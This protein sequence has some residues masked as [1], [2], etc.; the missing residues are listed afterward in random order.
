MS[1]N[2]RRAFLENAIFFTGSIAL[3]GCGSDTPKKLKT[4]TLAKDTPIPSPI[5]SPLPDGLSEDHFQLHNPQPLA[6][7]SKREMIGMSPITSTKRLFVRNNLPRPSDDIITNA[8]QWTLQVSGVLNPIVLSLPQLK[9]LGIETVTAVL[10]CSGNGRAFFTHEPSGSPWATGAAGCVQWTGV[11]VDD[12]LKACG[13]TL[14]SMN[15]LTATGGEPLP[16]D[17]PRNKA[18]VERSIPLKK[19]LKDCILAWELNGEPIPIS[20]GGPLRLIVPGYFGCNQIK[21]V[22]H[23][24]ATVEQS[25]AKI[26]QSGYRL[27]PIGEKGNHN[28]PSMWRMPVKSWVVDALKNPTNNTYIIHG[29]AFS[30]E[31]GI[32]EVE[33]S[34]D[35]VVWKKA[36]LYGPDLGPNAWRCFRINSDPNAPLL[37]IY[38]RAKD[39]LGEV[40]P[41]VRQE[42]ER[43]YGN[44]S[45]LDHG[46]IVQHSNQQDN[47]EQDNLITM[48]PEQ[49]KK[50]KALFTEGASPSCGTCHTLQ[51][52]QSSGQIGPNLDQLQPTT[53]RV[54]RAVE[55][56][57]GAMPSYGQQLSKEE[58]KTLA[59]YVSHSTKP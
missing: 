42:N 10:Q 40:Q 59:D 24:A 38:T 28:Q 17:I 18:V 13:G 12:V 19:A 3:H 27:R 55:N 30:G 6:L 15:Y 20:H 4:D 45:W 36:E 31:R 47:I 26:Q 25:Q 34:T 23:I 21:Y 39:T 49:K 58:I 50:G 11:R 22:K 29:I 51:E 9:Q 7:E 1:Q 43:G 8:H 44:N 16:T 41:K 52:A 5:S 33:Y 54:Q 14:S 35:T 46:Y 37:Q 48:T 32:Q 56:G 57:V 53:I 2:N